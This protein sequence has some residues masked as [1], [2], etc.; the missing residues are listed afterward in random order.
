MNRHEKKPKITI[1]E[2]GGANNKTKKHLP[3]S[4]RFIFD[5]VND[6]FSFLLRRMLYLLL[7]P[8]NALFYCVGIYIRNNWR[9]K[10]IPWLKLGLMCLLVYLLFQKEMQ[11][12]FSINSPFANLWA[13]QEVSAMPTGLQQ[14][15][16]TIPGKSNQLDAF[17]E[18][19]D[20][21]AVKTYI[22]RFAKVA[23]QEMNKYDIPASIKMGQAIMES[24]AGNSR[25]AKE[26]NNHFGI[27]CRKKCRGCTCRNYADDGI[28]DMFRVFEG[29]W[30]SWREHSLLL[31]NN[32]RYS[33]LK[34]N[35]K[36]YKKWAYGLKNAGYA[37]DKQYAPKLIRLIEKYKLYKLDNMDIK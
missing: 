7:K 36:D 18:S 14:N 34:K 1:L 4:Q 19:V 3:D 5:Y 30:D 37:T 21:Q 8:I 12:N 23:I 11:F 17:W 10:N 33:K 9:K 25:L 26:S 22:Q 20:D 32:Q 2:N 28:Y 27:K 6:D 29:A 35:G 24:S 31:S 15:V 13:S 16:S